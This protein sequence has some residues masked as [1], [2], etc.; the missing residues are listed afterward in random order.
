MMYTFS[1]Q[2]L[3]ILKQSGWTKERHV[4]IDSYKTYFQETQQPVSP[5]IYEFLTSFGNLTITFPL[6]TKKEVDYSFTVNPTEAGREIAIKTLRYYSES[7]IKKPLC[8][9]GHFEHYDTLVM[10]PIGEA[11]AVYDKSVC[12]WGNTISEAIE[13]IILANYEVIP[14]PS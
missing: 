11:Y 1:E 14:F 9:V 7:W 12:K 4:N 3:Q 8:C 2:I 13:N 6:Q 10:T 5:L